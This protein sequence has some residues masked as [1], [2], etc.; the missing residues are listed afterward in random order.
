MTANFFALA[1][2]QAFA[3]TYGTIFIKSLN[4]YNPY[5]FTIIIKVGGILGALTFAFL[6]DHIG[7]RRFFQT[8][9]PLAAA[10]MMII[11][12]VGTIHNPSKEIKLVIASMFPLYGY[13]LLGSFVPL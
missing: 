12:G 9:A 10:C 3:N 7:R 13:F 4:V 5:V 2:G 6:S 1:S 8:L 11:G